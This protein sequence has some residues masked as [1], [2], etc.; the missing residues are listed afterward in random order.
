MMKKSNLLLLLLG[1]LAF[2][3]CKKEYSFKENWSFDTQKNTAQIQLQYQGNLYVTA[4]EYL[5]TNSPN[6]LIL[7]LDIKTGKV[8]WKYDV[9]S[10]I[11]LQ[12]V[13]LSQG[14]LFVKSIE[15]KIIWLDALT[16]KKLEDMSTAK[17]TETKANN[18][19]NG[20]KVIAVA[21]N[22]A[23]K[24]AAQI[25]C[26][27]K[28]GKVIWVYKVKPILSVKEPYQVNFSFLMDGKNLILATYDGKVKSIAIT[29]K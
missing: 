7:C 11:I 6:H 12:K 19:F 22:E 28:N 24:K 15:D 27:D 26:K 10:G 20:N 13:K 21:G 14:K 2:T 23:K 4:G 3:A 8:K 18:T 1:I 17:I 9:G 16:G 25:V 29:Q 5:N